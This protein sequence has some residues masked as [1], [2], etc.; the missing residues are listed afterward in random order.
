MTVKDASQ[1]WAEEATQELLSRVASQV[2]PGRDTRSCRHRIKNVDWGAA[3]LPGR[4]PEACQDH[5]MALYRKI[6]H[7]KTLTTVVGEMSKLVG[8]GMKDRRN[9]PLMPLHRFLKDYY[10]TEM[11]ADIKKKGGNMFKLGHEA[12]RQ[13]PAE[14]KEVYIRTYKDECS[15]LMLMHRTHGW[16]SRG[17]VW[18]RR[19][20][21]QSLLDHVSEVLNWVEVRAVTWP[22]LY[23]GYRAVIKPRSDRLG[24]GYSPTNVLER[25]QTFEKSS[26]DDQAEVSAMAFHRC[27]P[28]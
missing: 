24:S 27:F 28:L 11:K 10:T 6:D 9:R 18:S 26:W 4:T 20:S 5:F 12:W 8:S 15:R 7:L 23:E 2:P 21:L 14:Q 3:A 16:P 17:C 1:S 22:I 19:L 13:L 25:S